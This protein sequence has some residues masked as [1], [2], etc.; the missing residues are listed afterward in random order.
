MIREGGVSQAD[1]DALAL[2]AVLVAKDLDTGRV[3]EAMRG[4]RL[5]HV[6]LRYLGQDEGA[7]HIDAWERGVALA[8]RV[9]PALDRVRALDHRPWCTY[10]EE[11]EAA[12]R[13]AVVEQAT[14]AEQARKEAH[15]HDQHRH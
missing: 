10:V 6:F 3:R 1:I 9:A 8:E 2:L 13:Y 14:H 7:V 12:L 11:L 15:G 5:V 4:A